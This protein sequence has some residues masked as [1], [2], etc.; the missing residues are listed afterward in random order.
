MF[1]S[2]ARALRWAPGQTHKYYTRLERPASDKH[3]SFL[4]T[5]VNYDRKNFIFNTDTWST[6]WYS[7]SSLHSVSILIPAPGSNATI[8]FTLSPL[9]LFPNISKTRWQK[10]KIEI[11]STTWDYSP[12]RY[13]G[14]GSVFLEKTKNTENLVIHIGTAETLFH[15]NNRQAGHMCLTRHRWFSVTT[16]GHNLSPF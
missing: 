9:Q 1:P 10:L 3:S 4:R 7:Y 16:P 14:L 2:K 11:V 8:F 6:T 5:L 12:R 13:V 15:W